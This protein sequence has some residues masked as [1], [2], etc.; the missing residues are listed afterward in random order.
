MEA[1]QSRGVHINAL[2]TSQYL[3]K[4][5]F[6]GKRGHLGLEDAHASRHDGLLEDLSKGVE[7][8]PDEAQN[9]STTYKNQY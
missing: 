4:R 7:M 9:L 3:K 2:Q 8:G 6:E 5:Q 1:F